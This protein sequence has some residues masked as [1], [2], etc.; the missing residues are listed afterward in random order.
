MKQKLFSI[1]IVAIFIVTLFAGLVYAAVQQ[2]YRMN[3][4]DPQIQLAEDLSITLANGEP[5][6]TLGINDPKVDLVHSLAIFFSVFDETGKLIVSSADLNGNAPV[7]PQGV[8]DSA[9]KNE[10]N[11]FTWQPEKDIRIATV[12]VHYKTE[13]AS[14]FILV[15]RS[16]RE[17]EKRED[18]LTKQ[19]AAAWLASILLIGVTMF[20]E[21]KKK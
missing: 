19:V 1:P 12:I 6:P 8:F 5:A 18:T 17:V 3:A 9:R 21:R 2:N 16:L 15:G 11:R 4:N 14:G 7:P 13:K 20:Y 10:Q